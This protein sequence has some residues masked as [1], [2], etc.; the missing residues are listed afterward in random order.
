MGASV[1]GFSHVAEGQ[2]CQDYLVASCVGQ[3]WLVGIVSD[4]AGSASRGADGSRA[5][6]EGLLRHL[7]DYLVEFEQAHR[8][9]P[10]DELEMRQALIEGI[11]CTRACLE[12]DPTAGSLSDF[13]ATVIGVVAGPHGGFLFHIG[14]GAGCATNANSFSPTIMS[15]AENGDYAN[16]TFFFTQVDWQDHLRLTR[17]DKECDLIVLMSDGVS[18]FALGPGG[19]EPYAP[20]LKPLS[21]YFK[22]NSREQGVRALAATLEKDDIRPIT[23]DD[24]TLLWALRVLL[25][26]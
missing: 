7:V 8:E 23:G 5:I 15:Q 2:P 10:V 17:F 25:D 3:G 11:E 1:T 18:P 13:H 12:N 24:K 26:G 19:R 6:C 20:F 21:E 16:E 22:T 14:D 9:R 4:G